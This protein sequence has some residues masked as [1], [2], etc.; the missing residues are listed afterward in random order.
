MKRSLVFLSV[1]DSGYSR[2][3]TYISGISKENHD[4]V[5]RKISNG[6]ILS[7]LLAIRRDFPKQS[8]FVVTS[9]GQ[10][11]VPLARLILGKRIVLDA[12]WSQFEGSFIS[13]GQVG[14]LFSRVIK[15]YLLD[16]VSSHLAVKIFLESN[17][18]LDFYSRVFL[19]S[20]KKLQ[21]LYTGVDENA[22]I[23]NLN[24]RPQIQTDVPVIM[25]RGKY[26]PESGL[27]ILAEATHLLLDSKI[28]FL[29]FSQGIP[30]NISFGS[31]TL[32]D[33]EKHSKSDFA[34]LLLNCDLSLGQLSSHSRLKRTIPHKAFESAFLGVPYLTGRNL[35]VLELFA[36]D[37]E[38]ACFDPGNSRDLAEKILFLLKEPKVRE[39]LG[40]NMRL[41]YEIKCSQSKLASQFLLEMS[42]LEE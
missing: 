40:A 38:I 13:R 9:P 35:G 20:R 29:V 26:N 39:R 11:I 32:V 16:F 19:V 33:T 2:S 10:Y 21:V 31:N 34:N 28:Q 15:N 37:T 36:E 42:K 18:Q 17:L 7:D 41:K 6:K 4:I 12:G 23:P 3:W 1:T 27:E 8:L 30:K 14:I 24:F 22:F 5:F 25:F